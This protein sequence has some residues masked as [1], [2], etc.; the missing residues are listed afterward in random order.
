MAPHLHCPNCN[1]PVEVVRPCTTT[2]PILN[3]VRDKVILLV[4]R[5]CAC[6][7]EIYEDKRLVDFAGLTLED[8]YECW[9]G[10]N[11]P[12]NDLTLRPVGQLVFGES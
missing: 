8:L 7:T 6:A 1:G 12:V 3:T 11:M 9:P 2:I 10:Q 5:G 4:C